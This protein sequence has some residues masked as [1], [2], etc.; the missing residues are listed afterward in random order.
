MLSWTRRVK[1]LSALN[2]LPCIYI[3]FLTSDVL[4]FSQ[5]TNHHY[6]YILSHCSQH[7]SLHREN[8][9]TAPSTC[10]LPMTLLILSLTKLNNYLIVRHDHFA[11]LYMNKYIKGTLITGAAISI[12]LKSRRSINKTTNKQYK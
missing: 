12:L 10:R 11:R 1:Q 5:A 6:T 2:C 3:Y 7:M 9:F 4:P 8:A